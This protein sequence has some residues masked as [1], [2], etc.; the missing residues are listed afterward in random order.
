MG[1]SPTVITY[2]CDGETIDESRVI[3]NARLQECHLGPDGGA[4]GLFSKEIGLLKVAAVVLQLPQVVLDL[5]KDAQISRGGVNI[6]A[7]LCDP[8]ECL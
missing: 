3:G 7:I 5:L 1:T 4:L 2:C 6:S 8:L